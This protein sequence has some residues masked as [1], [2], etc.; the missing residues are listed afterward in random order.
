MN[1]IV[2]GVLGIF[3]GG[4]R[5][6]VEHAYNREQATRSNAWT[7]QSD[8]QIIRTVKEIGGELGIHGPDQ[9]QY[10]GGYD[11]VA[12]SRSAY[13]SSLGYSR[14]GGIV[15]RETHLITVLEEFTRASQQGNTEL[16]QQKAA[17]YAQEAGAA[18]RSDGQIHVGNNLHGANFRTLGGIPV[19]EPAGTPEA[20]ANT[21]LN[22]FNAPAGASAMMHDAL[23]KQGLAQQ[24]AAPVVAG[25]ET[26]AAAP[27]QQPAPTQQ[28]PATQHYVGTEPAQ[29]PTTAAPAQQPTTAAPTQQPTTAAPAQQQ[30]TAAPTQQPTTA[31]PAQQPTTAAPETHATETHDA[32]Q[33]SQKQL[34]QQAQM[35]LERMGLN[36]G[37]KNEHVFQHA[38]ADQDITAKLDG[39][40]GPKTTAALTSAGIDPNKP[41]TAETVALLKEKAEQHRAAQLHPT[42]EVKT[43]TAVGTATVT[44]TGE[45]VPPPPPAPTGPVKTEAHV[46]TPASAAPAV[47]ATANV[48]LTP[49]TE[50]SL[51][52]PVDNAPMFKPTQAETSALFA[53][54]SFGPTEATSPA[55]APKEASQ[56]V[57]QSTAVQASQTAL[58]QNDIA[59]PP[60]TPKA[61]G[62]AVQQ[63]QTR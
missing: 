42:A 2:G 6:D 55:T 60:A 57:A 5:T 1:D 56:N 4:T 63:A 18:L 23:V 13:Q 39:I 53:S 30:T 16:A 25:V 20:Y 54:A 9:Q 19:P 26:S 38:A 33:L 47:A 17:Q 29:Q 24:T 41:I 50:A 14:S 22:Q 12:A 7:L 11:S 8:L 34:N 36:T 15:T 10:Y 37:N 3:N 49:L 58:T 52:K 43:T 48:H 44:T 59:S 46:D 51:A 32:A 27:A 61:T 35:Y 21:L 31:A 28:Q 40:V 45:H 62:P